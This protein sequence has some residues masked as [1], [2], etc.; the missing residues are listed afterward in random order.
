[1]PPPRKVDLLPPDLRAWLKAAFEARGFGGYE[2]IAD[3]LNKR[4]TAEGSSLR[5]A[6]TAVAAF[7]KE[8]REFVRL[9]EES[10]AWTKDWLTKEGLEGE[11]ETHKVLF[12]MISA[13]VFK[14]LQAMMVEEGAPEP[15][16]LAQ[17]GQLLRTLIHS[18]GIREKVVAEA[19]ERA[20]AEER[21]RMA[22]AAE[23]A[24]VRAGLTKERAQELRRELL[25]IAA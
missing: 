14:T 15:K 21:E 25:G 4:L 11:A 6:K 5:I 3:A 17:L 13:L 12:Q 19:A 10:Q 7:G 23:G 2:E 18:S 9:Q 24:A 22:A 8:H 16:A 20:K 1:M